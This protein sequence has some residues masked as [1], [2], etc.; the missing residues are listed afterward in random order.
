MYYIFFKH[1]PVNGYLGCIHVL[2]IVNS[3]AMNMCSILSYVWLFCNR[4]NCS[5][6]DSSVHG[7]FPAR[8]LEWVAIS[9]SKG[10]FQTQGSNPGL[11]HCRRILYH[12]ATW[13][14]PNVQ[15]GRWKSSGDGWWG[16]WQ[17]CEET[18]RRWTVHLK[19]WRR[20]M[21]FDAFYYWIKSHRWVL[22]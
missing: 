6:P 9:F 18:S 22:L 1:S 15:L 11:L 17:Q 14:A 4:M 20:F 13:E 12:W 5:L 19:W 7:I 10:I 21:L 16:R 8:I 3:A 2:P